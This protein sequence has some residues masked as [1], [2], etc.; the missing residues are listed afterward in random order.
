MGEARTHTST[1]EGFLLKNKQKMERKQK[2]K[3]L[4]QHV[5]YHWSGPLWMFPTVYRLLQ[6]REYVP[7]ATLAGSGQL[8][9]AS[10]NRFC[11]SHSTETETGALYVEESKMIAPGF[12][13]VIVKLCFLEP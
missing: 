2:R 7:E 9:A 4:S 1:F 13:L 6:W 8:P 5:T 12:E 11:S 10:Q 3:L